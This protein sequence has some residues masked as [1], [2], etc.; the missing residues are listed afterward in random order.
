MHAWGVRSVERDRLERACI[1]AEIRFL[2]RLER[3]GHDVM[4][5]IASRQRV[6]SKDRIFDSRTTQLRLDAAAREQGVPEWV[7]RVVG[8]L[9]MR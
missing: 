1:R 4:P 3:S 5:L 8:W 9:K 2:E 7:I 6:L